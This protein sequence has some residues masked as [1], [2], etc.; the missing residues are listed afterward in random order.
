MGRGEGGGLVGV[1]ETDLGL[2]F[3]G[4]GEVGWVCC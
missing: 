3:G 4:E 1:V 2:L